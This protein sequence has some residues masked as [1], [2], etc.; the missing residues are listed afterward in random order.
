MSRS[1]SPNP[2]LRL[3]GNRACDFG[4]EH[5]PRLELDIV[6]EDL[7]R[8]QERAR[9]A[10]EEKDRELLS[11]HNELG[12]L[13]TQLEKSQSHTKD[14]QKDF[15]KIK[16]ELRETI[17]DY[18]ECVDQREENAALV[19][20]NVDI[21]V[22]R[23]E[24]LNTTIKDLKRQI[25]EITSERDT[26]RGAQKRQASPS[27]RD[28]AKRLKTESQDI[29]KRL[30]HI[31]G[32]SADLPENPDNLLALLEQQVR[33]L[34]EETRR[35]QVAKAFTPEPRPDLAE[36]IKEEKQISANLREKLAFA[37]KLIGTQDSLRAEIDEL[38]D[39]R[40][41]ARNKYRD[42]ATVVQ[43]HIPELGLAPVN[44][45]NLHPTLK[46]V[47]AFARGED[48]AQLLRTWGKPVPKERV[49]FPIVFHNAWTELNAQ[50]QD[51]K[52]G[53]DLDAFRKL[54]PAL[55]KVNSNN[56]RELAA[57]IS[58][59]ISWELSSLWQYLPHEKD[60]ALV[61]P[62][63]RLGD[64][65]ERVKA[66]VIRQNQNPEAKLSRKLQ[67]ENKNLV[68]EVTAAQKLIQEK[69]SLLDFLLRLTTHLAQDGTTG[70][71]Q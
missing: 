9:A 39:A 33:E 52:T 31:L 42:I 68:E 58:D 65:L 27:A 66:A 16:A 24:K 44:A 10:L 20:A 14:L 21:A 3:P 53:K 8:S 64:L 51:C 36:E 15:A 26:L 17:N 54:L 34:R 18:N 69:G 46:N 25:Q 59:A 35:L 63:S 55:E 40:D 62:S 23:E 4:T 32:D 48:F 6:R 12:E 60:E 2:S 37:N 11:Y 56:P 70:G 38:K 50:L 29:R 30:T 45:G 71:S 43:D 7:R 19:Q 61:T 57:A 47:V 67:K 49:Q 5:V 13:T 28:E 41:E 1:R 22:K